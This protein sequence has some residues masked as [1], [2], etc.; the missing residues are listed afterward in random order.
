[1]K[2]IKSFLSNQCKDSFEERKERW[3]QKLCKNQLWKKVK[4]LR[5]QCWKHEM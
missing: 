1:M 2:N 5:K 4:T 3:N